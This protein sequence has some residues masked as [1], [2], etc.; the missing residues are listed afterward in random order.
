MLSVVI[1]TLNVAA[2][3][4]DTLTALAEG[5]GEIVVADGGSQDGTLSLAGVAGCRVIAAPRGRGPQ[6]AAAA[7]TARGDWL[8][9]L[10][11]DT[12][13]APGWMNEV[14]RFIADPDNRRR[15]AYF[16]FVLD[17]RSP[18]ARRL[19]AI[20]AW[21]ARWLGLPYGD[22]GLLLAAAFY[23]SLG[24]F[25]PLPL[26]EDVDLVRRIG[27]R[28]LVALDHP[29]VTSA[30]R[31]RGGYLRRSLRNL[32]CLSLYFAGLPPARIA[33]LYG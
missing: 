28:R 27:R 20:V 6:L 2:L 11:A 24:G 18:S 5:D 26:M 8:L 14:G 12:R 31:Y 19:E 3:L 10:H 9:F 22:Q 29:A 7:A 15:A 13:L 32:V 33:R 4:P 25:Q 16:R 21:R 23:R 17:D 1:P 30:A